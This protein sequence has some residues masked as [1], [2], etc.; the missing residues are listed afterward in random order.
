MPTILLKL[1]CKIVR[2]FCRT[3]YTGWFRRNL[4]YFGKW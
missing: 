2:Y 3:L 1:F 4:H